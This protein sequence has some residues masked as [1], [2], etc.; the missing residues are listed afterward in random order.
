MPLQPPP[1]GE[2]EIPDLIL[3]EFERLKV[4]KSWSAEV[5][6]ADLVQRHALA[7][8]RS[9]KEVYHIHGRPEP[10]AVASHHLEDDPS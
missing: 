8:G 9:A 10:R 2:E 7:G 1:R 6:P 4:L 5:A 3:T